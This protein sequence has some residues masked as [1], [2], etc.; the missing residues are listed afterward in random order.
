MEVSNHTYC[1]LQRHA[2]ASASGSAGSTWQCLLLSQWVQFSAN[3]IEEPLDVCTAHATLAVFALAWSGWLVCGGCNLHLSVHSLGYCVQCSFPSQ[4][5]G[6]H[7]RLIV[8]IGCAPHAYVCCVTCG[9]STVEALGCLLYSTANNAQ[10]S[11]R[12]T[13]GPEPP[14]NSSFPTKQHKVQPTQTSRLCRAAGHASFFSSATVK[15][16]LLPQWLPRLL[17]SVSE[18]D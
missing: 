5:P 4:P 13:K 1:P 8:A 9:L 10:Q 6:C 2:R 14:V 15:H 12:K 16:V 11:S 7:T 3:K 18:T 17:V